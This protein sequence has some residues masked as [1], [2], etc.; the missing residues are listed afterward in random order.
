MLDEMILKQKNKTR[1]LIDIKDV[2]TSRD[3]K[4][5]PSLILREVDAVVSERYD[6]ILPV[7]FRRSRRD[8]RP[9]LQ[10]LPR[11]CEHRAQVRRH[12]L[13]ALRGASPAARG[14]VRTHHQS[15]AQAKAQRFLHRGNLI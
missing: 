6:V 10:P 15:H 8:L 12:L 2:S 13:P 1:I 3:T 9:P 11:V 14:K 5:P 4:T 7:F